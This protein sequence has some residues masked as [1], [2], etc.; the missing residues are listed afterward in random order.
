MINS[1][2]IGINLI[3]P[4]FFTLMLFSFAHLFNRS[5]GIQL[6]LATQANYIIE[7]KAIFLYTLFYFFPLIMF[8]D[9]LDLWVFPF[10]LFFSSI[11]TNMIYVYPRTYSVYKTNFWS[12]ERDS[13]LLAIF[14]NAL[15]SI[16]MVNFY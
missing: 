11:V 6:L 1:Y 5:G 2:N 10:S 8:I 7:H 12:F 14:V 13:F 3:Y 9:R 4:S 16:I 15:F